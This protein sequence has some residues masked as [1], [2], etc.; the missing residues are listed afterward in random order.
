MSM[1][2]C[3]YVGVGCFLQV[4]ENKGLLDKVLKMAIRAEIQTQREVCMMI[5]LLFYSGVILSLLVIG[6]VFNS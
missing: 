4:F 3:M 6:H 5:E 1:Y 2:V